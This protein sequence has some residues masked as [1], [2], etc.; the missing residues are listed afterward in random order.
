MNVSD[1]A[2]SLNLTPYL[3]TW[4]K[5]LASFLSLVSGPILGTR[6]PEANTEDW[7]LQVWSWSL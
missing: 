4:T 5:A 2:S 7:R 3:S 1:L 6:R